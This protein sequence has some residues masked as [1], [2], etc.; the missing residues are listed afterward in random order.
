LP[1]VKVRQHLARRPA[2][3]AAVGFGGASVPNLYHANTEATY[4]E[5]VDEELVVTKWQGVPLVRYNLED[6]VRFLAWK[7]LCRAVAGD[8]PANG[9]LWAGM[10]ALELP[11]VVAVSGRSKGCVFLCGS[12]IF[13]SMLQ[14]VLLR[15][16][17]KG[18]ATGA[19][20]AWTGLA[21]GRQVLSWQIEL[22]R[23]VAPPAS[24]RLDALHREFVELL[25]QQQPEFGDDYETFYRPL[26]AEGMR[27]FQFH[28]CE[29]PAL[30]DHPRYA[31]G[32]K[33]KVIVEDGPFT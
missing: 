4:L 15:S 26:E 11:D 2:L 5:A 28:F 18:H 17:L 33:R 20:I 21:K 13:E 1:L 29:G 9:R 30:S 23:G 32:V 6:K 3:A 7:P 31:A 27:I 10:E 14:E 24:G 19:F 12:N 22:K 8:D 16:S 25:S